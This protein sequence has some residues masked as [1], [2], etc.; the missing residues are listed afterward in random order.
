[1]L[2]VLCVIKFNYKAGELVNHIYSMVA[3]VLPISSV[4]SAVV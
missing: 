2:S 4:V 1:M 3:L